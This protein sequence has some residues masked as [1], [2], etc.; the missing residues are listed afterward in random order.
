MQQL[1]LQVEGMSCG[2]CVMR[3]TE[4]LKKLPSVQLQ[5][6]AIGRVVLSHDP[7][8]TAEADIRAALASAGYPV[9]AVKKAA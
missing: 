8:A 4:T 7:Q 3:V 1:E 2:H 5:S 6:V 9:S